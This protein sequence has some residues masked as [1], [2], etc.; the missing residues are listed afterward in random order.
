MA[1]KKRLPVLNARPPGGVAPTQEDDGG[2]RPG[3]H[4]A[5]FGAV[6]IF[7]AW[8]PLAYAAQWFVLRFVLARFGVSQVTAGEL[9][10][11]VQTLGPEARLSLGVQMFAP[12]AVALALAAFAGGF[13]V[14]RFGKGAGPREAAVS[15]L[16]TS[17]VAAG[18]TCSASGASAVPL[19]TLLFTVP[20]AA[21]GA[22]FGR[23]RAPS[24][25]PPPTA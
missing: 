18:L 8:L 10:A 4:W 16:L 24:A 21:V 20:A 23:R 19:V 9:A 6:A 13:V 2:P 3:W 5:G 12:H 22:L 15:G 1:D 17:L 25:S 7:T 11:L 14:G